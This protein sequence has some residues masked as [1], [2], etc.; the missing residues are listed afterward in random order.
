M[1]AWNTDN[2][3]SDIERTIM[4]ALGRTHSL[5][6]ILV[7]VS[8][9]SRSLAAE[10]EN[11]FRVV[12]YVPNWINLNE[13]SA[14]IPYER[15]THIN[16]AFENPINENGELSFHSANRSLIQKAH[17]NGVKVL[18]SIGGG[19]SD[20]ELRARYDVLQSPEKR[21]MFAKRLLDYVIEHDFDG[22]DVDIEGPAITAQYGPF[23]DAVA[24][25][26]QPT[27]KLLTAAFSQ[28]YG[29]KNVSDE[30]LAKFDF[31]NI[32][33]YDGAG[34]WNPNDARQHSSIEFA[35][36]NTE[37]WL[38]R[39]LPKS[40]AVLGVP[41]YGYGFG[42]D[43]TPSGITYYAILAKH[44]EAARVDQ[45]G[46]TIWYNGTETI[47]AKT[48]FALDQRLGG[49]MIWSLNQDANDKN[50]LLRV[51]DETIQRSTTNPQNK[52]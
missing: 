52:K 12:A 33:A 32:M 11:L 41:F 35:K 27:G 24:E 44:R 9:S 13:F 42:S 21:S 16:I 5:A 25:V 19:T 23:I 4:N 45:V 17:E 39:G 49:I 28:G 30:T 43:F 1:I 50:S 8:I 31:V 22:L 6:L 2:D 47:R 29:G 15:L 40:K 7:I 3:T 34:P 10:T 38:N 37:Y 18:V 20:E 46:D 36:S 26:F 48:E 51:I 14:S